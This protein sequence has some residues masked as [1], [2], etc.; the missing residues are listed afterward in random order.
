MSNSDDLVVELQNTVHVRTWVRML[1]WVTVT[2]ILAVVGLAALGGWGGVSLGV[3]A[4]VLI[5]AAFERSWGAHGPSV[6]LRLTGG[7][8]VLPTG[9]FKRTPVRVPLA[10]VQRAELVEGRVYVEAGHHASIFAM[11]EIVG[12]DAV[13][14]RLVDALVSAVER[15]SAQHAAR[16]RDR[17]A[18]AAQLRRRPVWVTYAFTGALMAT[19]ALLGLKTG[20]VSPTDA[21]ATTTPMLVLLGVGVGLE[22]A[23]GA[24]RFGS[25]L[26][27]SV[28]AA[29]LASW[30]LGVSVMMGVALSTLGVALAMLLVLVSLGLRAV[31]PAELRIPGVVMAGV[32][33]FGLAEAITLARMDGWTQWVGV[34]LALALSLWAVAGAAALM[35]R[36]A[37]AVGGAEGA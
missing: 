10:D 37:P 35:G 19:F 18:L 3:L 15:V 31:L 27:G 11:E 9:P 13:A 33:L 34:A 1:G 22:R 5:A 7:E 14:R 4:A 12:G 23:M 30:S 8:L 16:L 26:A 17:A 6:S 24:Q 36:A 25:A 28:L 21:R 2:G 29:M 32:G 20:L